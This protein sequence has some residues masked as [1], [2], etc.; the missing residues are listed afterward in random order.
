MTRTSVE[1][2]STGW[3]ISSGDYAGRRKAPAGVTIKRFNSQPV[4][5]FVELYGA[6][7]DSPESKSINCSNYRI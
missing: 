5:T 3:S 1:R 4:T 6:N 7:A 2:L